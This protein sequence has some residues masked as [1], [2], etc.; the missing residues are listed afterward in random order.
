MKL[1]KRPKCH[2]YEKCGNEAIMLLGDK[3][4]CYKCYEKL[5]KKFEELQD[6]ILLEE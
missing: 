5:R 4:I 2:Y 1:I 6:E 3:M